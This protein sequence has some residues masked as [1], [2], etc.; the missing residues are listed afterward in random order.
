MRIT[1]VR[2]SYPLFK[3]IGN[4][5]L[6]SCVTTGCSWFLVNAWAWESEI[7]WK[8]VKVQDR[9]ISCGC[10]GA[11]MCESYIKSTRYR[12]DSFFSKYYAQPD[13]NNVPKSNAEHKEHTFLYQNLF[14][15]DASTFL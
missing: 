13:I 11:D 1:F 6:G 12:T 7:L 10:L 5:V 3:S 8:Q 15:P 4:V 9:I 14:E 2:L